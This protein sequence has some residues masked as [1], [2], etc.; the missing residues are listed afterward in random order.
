MALSEMCPS[1]L[2]NPACFLGIPSLLWV[3]LCMSVLLAASLFF[4]WFKV[5][6][7]EDISLPVRLLVTLV[8]TMWFMAASLNG[9]KTQPN[10]TIQGYVVGASGILVIT[11]IGV[12]RL[13]ASAGVAVYKLVLKHRSRKNTP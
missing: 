10:D 6:G 9:I 13:L 3:T 2:F 5:T 7:S 1:D 4:W 8:F 11:G 12:S